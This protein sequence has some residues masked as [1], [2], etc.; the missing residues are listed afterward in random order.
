MC[1]DR[2]E[3]AA[4]SINGVMSADWNAEKQML[5]LSFNKNKTSLSKVEKAIANV[6]HDTE[7]FKANDS[8][9]NALPE[10]CRYRK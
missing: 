8:I 4:K 2:I 5:H 3:T 1:K 10:C 6:G 7:M 9:Y